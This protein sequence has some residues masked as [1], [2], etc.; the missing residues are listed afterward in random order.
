MNLNNLK[1]D[2]KNNKALL[3]MSIPGIVLLLLFAYYPMTGIVIAFQDYSL[4]QG[5]KGSEWIG[6]ENFM[7]FFEDPY[8]FRLLKNTLLLG[9]Y[10]GAFRHLSFLHFC[11]MK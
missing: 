11:S 9:I 4:F 5:I 8:F 6:F 1:Y 7:R 10:Y 2:W 3:L